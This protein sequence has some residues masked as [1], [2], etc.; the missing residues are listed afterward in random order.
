MFKTKKIVLFFLVIIFLLPLFSFFKPGL[1]ITH[2]GQDHVARIANFYAS[3]EEGNIVPRWAENLNWGYGHPILMFLYPLPS[4]F[5][6]LFH[7]LGLN[8][9]DSIKAVFAVAFILSG[10]TMYLWIESF[11]GTLPAVAAS[12]FYV[13]APYRFIDMYVRG[14]LGEH[15]AFIFPP[16]IL[17]FM[18]RFSKKLNYLDAFL[19]AISLAFLI[20]SHNA[21]SLMFMPFFLIYAFLLFLNSKNKR[22]IVKGFLCIFSFGFLLSAFFWLPALLEGKYTLRNIVTRG[23]YISRFVQFKDL[24]YGNWNFGITGEFSVQIGLI[25]LLGIFLSLFS[26]IFLFKKHKDLF[27]LYLFTLFYFLFAIFLML[28]YSNFIWKNIIIL[29]NFQFPWRFLEVVVFVSSLLGSFFIFCLPKNI[30]YLFTGL[31]LLFVIYYSSAF[32]SA[33]GYL[34]KPETFYSGIYK[35]TTDTG[36]SSPIWSVRFMEQA[37]ETHLE[38]IA[39]KARIKEIKRNSILHV[40]KVTALDDKAVIRENTLYFP[41]WEVLVDGKKTLI[42]F[43]DPNNRGVI[44]FSINKGKHDVLVKF[45]ETKL[46]KFADYISLVS[47]IIIL[48]AI[49]KMLNRNKKDK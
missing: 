9:V 22:E 36:E 14:A 42:E 3:L 41:G 1:P 17:F 45:E 39:G 40:Y 29:Q 19:G 13:F 44:T 5:S 12:V 10:I 48:L 28:P 7:F 32:W 38:I 26:I 34:I 46:R 2:D 31:C 15:V 27:L 43:Q 16:L 11:L 30:K 24:I 35:S 18:L 37:P 25:H 4:Y 6:S 33:K 23:E 49:Y 8:L 20:L 21:I 47:V